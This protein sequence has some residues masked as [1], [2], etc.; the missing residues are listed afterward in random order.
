MIRATRTKLLAVG[1]ATIAL[2]FTLL[3]LPCTSLEA[4][5]NATESPYTRFGYGKLSL[6]ASSTTRALGGVSIAT[7]KAN[8]V[9]PRNPASYAA[10]DSQTF[11]FDLASSIGFSYLREGER[12]DARFLGNLEYVTMLFPIT[13]WLALSTGLTPFS[14]VGYRFGSHN[15]LPGANSLSYTETYSGQGN[16]NDLYLGIGVMPFKQFT[17]GANVAYR[18]GKINHSRTVDFGAASTLNPNFYESLS[19]R[20]IKVDAGI[21]Y[22]IELDEHR[23]LTLGATYS[24]SL[25]LRSTLV[26]QELILRGNSIVRVV[27]RDTV[28]SDEAFR[29][30]HEIALGASYTVKDKLFVGADVQYSIWQ[31][32]FTDNLHFKPQNQISVALGGSFIPNYAARSIWQRIEYRFGLSG[33]NSYLTIPKERQMQGG[34]LQGGISFGMGIPLVDRRSYI[35]VT[36]DYN[37]L[38]PRQKGMI[39]EH[40]IQLTFGLRFNEGWFKKLKLD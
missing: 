30:P 8:L 39:S 19:V 26:E 12:G 3:L 14:T 16:I 9:N 20:G 34:Y 2:L 1:S 7:R 18:F 25:A 40:Y 11:I 4:Q 10:V 22:G 28:R 17:L 38:M 15:P 37:H 23:T 5:N 27:K 36:L 13:D 32:A 33:S 6:S 21:Q 31:H 35:D 29:T 24:P